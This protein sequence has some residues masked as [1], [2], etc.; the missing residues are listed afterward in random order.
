PGILKKTYPKEY[1]DLLNGIGIWGFRSKSLKEK[2][3]MEFGTNYDTFICSSGVPQE[4]LSSSHTKKR[5]ENKVKKF[6]YVGMFIPRKRVSDIIIALHKAF[7]LKDFELD[8]VGEGMERRN[9]EMLTQKLDLQSN[10]IFYGKLQ[11]D[12]VQ[13]ILNKADCFIMVSENEAFGLVYLEAMANGC[14]TIGSRG[15]GI[16]GVIQHG[17]NGF[18]CEA[19]NSDQLSEIIITINSLSREK[20]TEISQIAIETAQEM[21]DSK[22]ADRYLKNVL[23]N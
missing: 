15:E 7:P 14:I 13:I 17:L 21:T 19:G 3:E 8:I 4:Y 6:C 23:R 2:F 5:F 16:D 10:V 22:V 18:L 20:L 11:R 9:L 1:P 12:E